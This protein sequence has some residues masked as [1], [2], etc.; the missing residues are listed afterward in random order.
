ML[1]GIKRR[2]RANSDCNKK[3]KNEGRTVDRARRGELRERGLSPSVLI[4]T[5]EMMD[6][7]LRR[8]PH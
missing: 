4:I 3:E 2:Q 8:K 7:A 5:G 1:V 6:W